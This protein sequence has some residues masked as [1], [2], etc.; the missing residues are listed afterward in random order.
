M[1]TSRR[2]V[3]FLAASFVALAAAPGADAAPKEGGPVPDARAE[4]VDGRAFETRSYRGKKT[5][6]LFYEGKD[7]AQQNQRLK[8]DIA[9]LMRSDR[10]R[11]VTHFAAVA[12]VS[13]YDYW[14][15]KGLV[16]DKVREEVQKS[17]WPIYCDW[18]GSFRS[19]LKLRRDASN[20]VVVGRNGR[21]L[22]TAEGPV[23]AGKRERLF[24]VLRAEVEGG[25]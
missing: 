18:D 5:L 11:H 14:P 10:Y 24:N 17:G 1:L 22:F 9:K 6:I 15:V 4:D 3:L 21:V 8:V 16:K 12:D 2:A 25:A 19:A 23:D 20:V 13:D 7:T